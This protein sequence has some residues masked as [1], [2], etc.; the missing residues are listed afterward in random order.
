MSRRNFKVLAIEHIGI[1]TFNNS[2]NKFLYDILG[3]ANLN[4]EE[5]KSQNVITEIYDTGK[6]KLELL[7]ATSDDSPISKFLQKRGQGVHHIALSVDN[8]K[9]AIS[10]LQ[11]QNIKLINEKPKLGAEGYSTIFIHPHSSPGI[12]IELCQK[13]S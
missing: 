12:L 13:N 2:L 3:I 5:V 10:Y 9:N 8:L 4:V 1:A 11:E 6:G 7:K